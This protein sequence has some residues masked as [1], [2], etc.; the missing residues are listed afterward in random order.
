MP[1]PARLGD[2]Q[3]AP[4]S[5]ERISLPPLLTRGV[6]L[7][8]LPPEPTPP[9]PAPVVE[10]DTAAEDNTQQG[11]SS[12]K[13]EAPALEPGGI[14]TL[15]CSLS[16]DCDTALR[17]VYGP[18]A[19]CPYGEST[20]NPAANN[21]ISYGL[22]AIHA[23]TWAGYF[24]NFWRDW[25]IAEVNTSWAWEIYVRAGYSWGPWSCW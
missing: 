21:G 12:G 6:E 18:T 15:I 24:P 22:F 16:W 4:A 11:G 17:I 25:M 7:D 20:G 3:E 14:Q 23:G 13:V 9:T 19:K 10:G 5:W 8:A 1:L 2:S